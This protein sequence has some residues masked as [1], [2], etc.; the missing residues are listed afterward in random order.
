MTESLTPEIIVKNTPYFYYI[1]S[2]NKVSLS[3]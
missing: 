3:F 2:L 1:F